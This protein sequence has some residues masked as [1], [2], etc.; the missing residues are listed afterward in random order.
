MYD[1]K[2]FWKKIKGFFLKNKK[3]VLRIILVLLV[4]LVFILFFNE[5]FLK[6]KYISA[7]AFLYIWYP[8]ATVKPSFIEGVRNAIVSDWVDYWV[9]GFSYVKNASLNSLIDGYNVRSSWGMPA[10]SIMGIV[11]IHEPLMLILVKSFGEFLG[12]TLLFIIKPF[13]GFIG[14][15]LLSKK[16]N[17]HKF[18]ALVGSAAF[19]F[20]IPVISYTYGS[21]I[22]GTIALPFIFYACLRLEE[23]F[24]PMN[25]LLY[26]LP[27][28]WLLT[29]AFPSSIMYGVIFSF[30]FFITLIIFKQGMEK[31]K[32]IGIIML[33]AIINI[34]ILG[35]W[36]WSLLPNF[37]NLRAFD[38]DYRGAHGLKK[39]A[40]QHFLQW[41]YPNY[42]G[43]GTSITWICGSNWIETSMSSGFV[44]LLMLFFGSPWIFLK[45]RRKDKYKLFSFLFVIIIIFCL[46][47]NL[48]NINN[49]LSKLPIF[50]ITPNTRLVFLLPFF[51]SL[52]GIFS[53]SHI[54]NAFT[55]KENQKKIIKIW[56]ISGIGILGTFMFY[57]NGIIKH[58]RLMD[59]GIL[60]QDFIHFLLVAIV[61]MIL[62]LATL[63]IKKKHWKAVFLVALC[64]LSAFDLYYYNS[65]FL[66]Y[67]K[68]EEIFPITEGIEYLQDNM[69]KQDRM[70]AIERV[71]LPNTNYYYG[72]NSLTGHDWRTK[73]FNEA[74][75]PIE[76]GIFAKAGTMQFFSREKVL[77]SSPGLKNYLRFNR[78]KYI[79]QAPS[80]LGP[81][82]DPLFLQPYVS[83][84]ISIEKP[85]KYTITLDREEVLQF[86]ELNGQCD[87]NYKEIFK[88]EDI[89]I[90]VIDEESKST[91]LP[92]LDLKSSCSVNNNILQIQTPRIPLIEGSKIE[93]EIA[94]SRNWKLAVY[95]LRD[96]RKETTLEGR[97]DIFELVGRIYSESEN[98]DVYKEVYNKGDLLIHEISD[99][100][101]TAYFYSCSGFD[102]NECIKKLK[103]FKIENP[104]DL[105]QFNDIFEEFEEVPFI[106]YS[107]GKMSLDTSKLNSSGVIILTDNYFKG[108]GSKEGEVFQGFIGSLNVF[109]ENPI[110]VVKLTYTN[111]YLLPGIVISFLSTGIL[112][113]VL[114]IVR[115]KKLFL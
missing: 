19:A 1:K 23:E 42:C 54:V 44:S 37:V 58:L 91:V 7:G 3:I 21:A 64:F 108:W 20:S 77:L 103:D 16:L 63:Y 70:F 100:T 86:I 84:Y 107:E 65:K 71:F 34:L 89:K 30:F 38:L 93:L 76:N 18:V 40:K 106:D 47:F 109:V 49:L 82:T 112:A 92:I 75:Q 52:A 26:I 67:Q 60:K 33:F 115:K 8:W 28:I 79:V 94:N 53:F 80:S 56:I 17:I 27:V 11:S 6:G 83:D 57:S 12:S 88:A 22:I 95:S 87:V 2:I 32:K 81:D 114:L 46:I 4:V 110:D 43:N 113:G 39:L 29:C 31:K 9:A 105:T 62:I 104:K 73:A 13:I 90:T 25:V 45:S 55:K 97:N 5:F 99:Q 78:V 10:S 68:K 14:M 74:M 85:I 102:K 66:P 61:A 50:S 101:S 48:F 59:R 35:L 111:E 98:V 51:V 72:I 41:I 24:S 15:L 96:L 36:A 69:E